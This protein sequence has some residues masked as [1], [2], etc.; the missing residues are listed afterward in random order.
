MRCMGEVKTVY[1]KELLAREVIADKTFYKRKEA[2]A[3][4][5]QKRKEGFTVKTKKRSFPDIG[6]ESWEIMARKP[7]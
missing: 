7:K 2:L 4:A 6:E 3:Y 1:T 5:R